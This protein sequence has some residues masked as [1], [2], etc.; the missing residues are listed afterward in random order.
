MPFYQECVK[1]DLKSSSS[2]C[3]SAKKNTVLLS[4]FFSN[5]LMYAEKLFSSWNGLLYMRLHI[6]AL[7]SPSF[8]VKG[9]YYG[10][11]SKDSSSDSLLS[12]PCSV[13]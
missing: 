3:F 5:V 6:H 8:L 13:S 7:C 4:F 9:K 11:F 12:Q 10:V 1:L 2:N